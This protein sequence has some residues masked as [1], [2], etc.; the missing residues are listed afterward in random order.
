MHFLHAYMDQQAFNVFSAMTIDFQIWYKR[1]KKYIH[2]LYLYTGFG[3]KIDGPITERRSKVAAVVLLVLWWSDVVFYLVVQ[4]LCKQSKCAVDNYHS[5]KSDEPILA[6]EGLKAETPRWMYVIA[7][8][9]STI[10]L[11]QSSY[12][13]THSHFTHSLTL[14][15]HSHTVLW[16]RKTVVLCHVIYTSLSKYLDL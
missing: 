7:K 6:W 14:A 16:E 11:S 10:P 13:H 1:K 8:F 12:T 5:A 2:F 4:S 3:N 15:V 9:H